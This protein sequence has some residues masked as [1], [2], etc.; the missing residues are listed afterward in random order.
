LSGNLLK[1]LFIQQQRKFS[2]NQEKFP[3][4]SADQRRKESAKISEISGRRK[5]KGFPQI[6]QIN[7]ERESAKISEV[8]GRR[9]SGKVS[10]R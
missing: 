1:L 4:D 3:A 5:R 10:R 2:E 8:S 7:A 6:T 9:K